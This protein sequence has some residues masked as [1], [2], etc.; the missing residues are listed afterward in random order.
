MGKKDS[1]V[2]IC[3]TK[4]EGQRR[5]VIQGREG[6]RERER[7]KERKREGGRVS[8]CRAFPPSPGQNVTKLANS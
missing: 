7:K 1:F 5:F 3:N 4:L 2:H 6:E 8:V